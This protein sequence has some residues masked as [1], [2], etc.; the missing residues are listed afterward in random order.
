MGDFARPV[1]REENGQFFILGLPVLFT[2]KSARARRLGDILLADF[3]QYVIG[4][5]GVTI[6]SSGHVLFESDET[7]FRSILALTAWADG[8]AHDSAQRHGERHH[9]VGNTLKQERKRAQ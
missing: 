1:M 5:R 3:S 7:A 4:M 6:D 8:G 2:E 9:V